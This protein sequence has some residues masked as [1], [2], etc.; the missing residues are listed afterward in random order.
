MRT[1]GM[2]FTGWECTWCQD[3]WAALSELLPGNNEVIKDIIKTALVA[4]AVPALGWLVRAFYRLI[5]RL[6]DSIS[7]PDQ[8]RWKVER[9]QST[10][11]PKGPGLWLAIPKRRP[12]QYDD[13]MQAS[14]FVMTIAND[15]GGVGKTTTTVN[16][17][18]AF[19]ARLSKPVLVIDLDPQGSASAQMFAGTPW[20]PQSGMQSAASLAIDGKMTAAE[21]IGHASAARPFTWRDNQGTTRQ[22]PNAFGL[23][24]FYEL[25]ETEN[26]AV[27]EWQIGDRIRDIRYDL[28]LLLRESAIRAHFGAILIDAPP[29]FSISSIQALCASTHVLVPTILD[30]TSAAA[31][32]Y[33]GRQLR[34]HEE[35]WPY[36][37][38]IG[39]L[40]T[41]ASGLNFERESLRTAVDALA[42]NLRG[43]TT[44]LA[45]L[46]RLNVPFEIP[47]ELAVPDRAAIGRTGGNG[48]AYNSLGDN[49]QGRE[50]RELFDK[51]A[52]EL[53]WRMR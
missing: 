5:R 7:A 15:K 44:H 41:M 35:L 14:P 30:N 16:L 33:F 47:Y 13:W 21:L 9:A 19:A 10:V 27:T 49:A 11:D 26:R 45:D 25:T 34:R 53:E 39:I 36:L 29:R 31:V 18:A 17:A 28:F 23:A 4:I 20:I 3:V 42:D 22:T 12:I 2:M 24:A 1:G 43:T 37:K 6:F 40:G 38:V 8:Y 52:D 48:I 46:E 32:G 51:L 50:V